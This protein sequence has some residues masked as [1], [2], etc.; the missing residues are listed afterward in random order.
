MDSAAGLVAPHGR[1]LRR[2]SKLPHFRHAGR[3]DQ[4][5]QRRVSEAKAGVI[6]HVGLVGH[7]SMALYAR[8]CGWSPWQQARERRRG[9]RPTQAGPDV[10]HGD[11]NVGESLLQPLFFQRRRQGPR[12]AL[13]SVLPCWL[14]SS[15]RDATQATLLAWRIC[16]REDAS[17]FPPAALG[18]ASR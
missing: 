8:R 9:G 12:R 15:A 7:G 16:A 13:V 2:S 6:R 18:T 1:R 17:D 10:A 3:L 11:F 14:L 5:E 4:G